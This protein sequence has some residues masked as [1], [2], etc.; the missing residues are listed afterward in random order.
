MLER[1]YRGLFIG[2]TCVL[3][4]VSTSAGLSKS[5]A[6]MRTECGNAKEKLSRT[7][8]WLSIMSRTLVL[9]HNMQI[10]YGV[11]CYLRC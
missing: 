4:L 6:C 2:S 3:H 11:A 9:T 8:H 10:F 1:K 7:C 5:A